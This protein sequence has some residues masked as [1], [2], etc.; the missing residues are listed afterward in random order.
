M[1][2]TAAVS[3]II[4]QELYSPIALLM[5]QKLRDLYALLISVQFTPKLA[6]A[7]H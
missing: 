4:I 5:L 3:Q 1:R 6:N 7:C 2:S